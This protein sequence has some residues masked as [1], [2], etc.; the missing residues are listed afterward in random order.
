SAYRGDYPGAVLGVAFTPDGKTVASVGHGRSLHLWPH[1]GMDRQT[2][3]PP[4]LN[5]TPQPY[6]AAALS[7]SGEFLAVSGEGKSVFIINRPQGSLVTE[8]SGHDDVVAGIAFSPDGKLLATASYDKTIKLWNTE[9]WKEVHT[10][11]G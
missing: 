2:F 7:P 8:L 4:G 9:T 11:S 6:L 3:A 1:T 10:L 5:F